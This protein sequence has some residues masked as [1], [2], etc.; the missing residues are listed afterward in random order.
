MIFHSKQLVEMLDNDK[1][2]RSGMSRLAQGMNTD[3]LKYQNAADMVERLTNSANRRSFE[4]STKCL[5][6]DLPPLQENAS[7]GSCTI[8]VFAGKTWIGSPEYSYDRQSG[9]SPGTLEWLGSSGGVAKSWLD[10]NRS[11]CYM[12]LSEYREHSAVGSR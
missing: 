3:A 7:F 12:W 1:E 5:C 8:H 4:G 10:L 6:M 11:S 9:Q 2:E